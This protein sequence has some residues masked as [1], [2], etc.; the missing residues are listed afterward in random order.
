M[1]SGTYRTSIATKREWHLFSGTANVVVDLELAA[2]RA[3]P[4]DG[5][6][7]SAT[8]APG[9]LQSKSTH[10]NEP[11]KVFLPPR[12]VASNRREG[13]KSL[14]DCGEPVIDFH[15]EAFRVPLR[16]RASGS[17]VPVWHGR[18]ENAPSR[19]IMRS[20]AEE[21]RKKQK[22]QCAPEKYLY[23]TITVQVYGSQ[24]L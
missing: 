8:D 18:G 20:A 15:P 10:P 3:G 21:I 23:V 7:G 9:D 22:V 24:L 4:Q 14:L 6:A 17:V 16:C 11:R 2:A 19:A 1:P 12:G 13:K 5:G